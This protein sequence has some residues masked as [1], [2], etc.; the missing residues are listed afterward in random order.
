MMVVDMCV[1]FHIRGAK[2][3]AIPYTSKKISFTA[4]QN[5]LCPRAVFVNLPAKLIQKTK[6]S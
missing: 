5:A 4:G 2:I 3:M 1:L 6:L